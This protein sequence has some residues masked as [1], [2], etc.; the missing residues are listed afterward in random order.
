MIRNTFIFY[1]QIATMSNRSDNQLSNNL[2]DSDNQYVFIQL[3]QLLTGV[4]ELDGDIAKEYY[5]EYLQQK[6]G[7]YLDELIGIY[8]SVVAINICII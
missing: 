6:F 7:I 5:H 1:T 2:L 8:Q 4:D 3:S